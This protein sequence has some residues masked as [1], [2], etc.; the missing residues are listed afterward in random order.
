MK[1]DDIIQAAESQIGSPY[2]Y[3]TW[4]NAVCSVSLRKRYA[5]YRP[6]QRAITYARCQQLRDK[7]PKSSCDGCPYKGKLAFDCR[8]FVHW[9]LLK[10]GIDIEG[11]AVS[12]QW[13]SKTNWAEKGDIAAMPDLICAVFIKSG[14]TWKH[15]GLHLG[16]GKI[17]HC[18]GEVKRDQV[19]GERAW[20]Y[21]AIPNGLY[22]ADEIRQAHKGGFMRIL[23]KGMRGEDVRELQNML[24]AVGCDCGKADGVF[25]DKTEGAVKAFQFSNS[26]QYD[27]VVG[28]KTWNALKAATTPAEP[29]EP[30]QPELPEDADEFDIDEAPV[31][32]TYSD[33]IALLSYTRKMTEILEKALK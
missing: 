24:N 20:K 13:N 29:A 8:G 27:G 26:L 1:T 25:G 6:E 15:V 32:I 7:K 23:K 2:I 11:Q 28:L 31:M 16:G 33:L 17:I 5:S 19:G 18:S 30:D 12:T 4:G 22:S 10:A 14:S 3:G 9:C 21:Y